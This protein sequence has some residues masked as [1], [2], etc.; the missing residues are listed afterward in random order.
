MAI[1]NCACILVN[2][3]DMTNVIPDGAPMMWPSALMLAISAVALGIRVKYV[4][5][6]L[7]V[8]IMSLSILFLAV[9][10]PSTGQTFYDSGSSDVPSD[11]TLVAFLV[12]GFARK[13]ELTYHAIWPAV[14]AYS[15]SLLIGLTAVLGYMLWIPWM[16][17][18]RDP[19]H[20]AMSLSMGISLAILSIWRLRFYYRDGENSM[21]RL[22]G[23]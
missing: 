13:M 17:F 18:S 23:R 6:T 22:L 15:V 20:G 10:V 19:A 12:M 2:G 5:E 1:I 11:A 16:W 8:I 14:T 9:G 21:R 7:S 4:A 3:R